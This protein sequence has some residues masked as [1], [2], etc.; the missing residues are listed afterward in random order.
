MMRTPFVVVAALI[1]VVTLVANSSA[2]SSLL[3]FVF[4]F[5]VR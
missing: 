1:L 3:Q 2:G 4:S 5:T